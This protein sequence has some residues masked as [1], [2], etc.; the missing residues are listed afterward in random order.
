MIKIKEVEIKN[1]LILGMG[2]SAL[3]AHIIESLNIL[4]VPMVTSHEYYIPSWVCENTLVLAV[5]YSGTTEETLSA[6]NEAIER[7]AYIVGITTGGKLKEILE[8][9]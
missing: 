8:K 6:T 7:G 1:V 9:N 5:S 4:K 2:G 3:P